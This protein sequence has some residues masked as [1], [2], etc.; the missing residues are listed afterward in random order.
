MIIAGE[1]FMA[2]DYYEVLGVQR[3][4]SK[5]DIKKAFRKLA[6]EY[7]P[8]VSKHTDAEDKFKEI[9]EAYEV[10][11]DDDKRSRYDRFGAAGVQGNG[12]GGT[13]GMGG[14]SGFEEIFEEFFN[15]FGGSRTAARRR[16]PRPG[17]DRRVNVTVTFEESVFGVEQ[18][19][20]FD[21][22]EACE[23]C[24]GSG[25]EPGTTP[26]RCPDCKGTGELRQVQQT[27]LGAMV[28]ATTCPRC[29]GR[30]EINTSP[31]HT[32]NGNGLLR[33]HAVLPV[34]IPPGV[35]E[36][37][38]IQIKGEGDAGEY[39]APSGNLYVIIDA[40]EHKFFKRKDND[41][42]LD[43]TLNVAQATLG[44]KVQ[45]PT[46]DGDVELVIPPGTQT[47]KHFRLRGKGIPRL[48]SDGTNSGRGDQIVYVQ[49]AIPTNLTPEQRELFEKLA[50]TLG[51]DVH[52]QQN[53]RGFFER[54]MDFLA[55]EQS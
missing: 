33:K 21:R 50:T 30:G 8:D 2:R 1:N 39:G 4:A 52:P 27:F 54:V 26:S 36:G 47:G 40:K 48:R 18:Q 10:L 24:H 28:R 23:T 14:M 34:H 32:C 45:V 41:I 37:L 25:A 20:E 15:N 42:I 35:R 3:N 31:C 22:L 6:R 7:H 55:G 49:V 12:F 43:I 51:T 5:D 9:N 17:A 53:G 44:D 46:V 29:N 11:S 38:Q 19:I 16:G 13:G